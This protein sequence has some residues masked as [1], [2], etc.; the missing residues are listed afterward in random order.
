MLQDL[1]LSYDAH[2]N[3]NEHCKRKG[4]NFLSTAFDLDSINLLQKFNPQY[5][6]IPSGEIT[7]L[8]YLRHIGAFA[9]PVFL[10]TGMSNLG[11]IESALTILEEAGTNRNS[12]TVLHCT[13]EY[14]APLN[15][16]NLR[17]LLLFLMLLVFL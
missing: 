12:I 10:S 14:P 8:P 17:A 2:L 1:E 13:S 6:K 5:W 7:N 16:V 15:E 9:Q 4:I 11:D 3:I